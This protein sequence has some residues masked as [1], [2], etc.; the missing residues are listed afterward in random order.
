[1]LLNK[2]VPVNTPSPLSAAACHLLLASVLPGPPK[3]VWPVW[4]SCLA[5]LC[6]LSLGG[7]QFLGLSGL[8]PSGLACA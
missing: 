1:M 5:C 4:L 8:A 6:L 7:A 2:S 3:P